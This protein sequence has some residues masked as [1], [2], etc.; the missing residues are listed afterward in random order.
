[1]GKLRSAIFLIPSRAYL[2]SCMH[3]GRCT[4]ETLR[5]QVTKF[6]HFQCVINNQSHITQSNKHLPTQQAVLASSQ[7]DFFADLGTARGL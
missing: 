4:G 7:F 3:L 2:Q 6:I 5:G 1:M